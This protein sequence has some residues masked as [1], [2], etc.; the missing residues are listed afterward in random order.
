MPN[1]VLQEMPDYQKTIYQLSTDISKE[2]HYTT[3]DS[4]EQPTLEPQ[5][6][7][8]DGSSDDLLDTLTPRQDSV[9][10]PLVFMGVSILRFQDNLSKGIDSPDDISLT[11]LPKFFATIVIKFGIV[12]M[13]SIALIFLIILNLFRIFYLWF[14]IV[15]A[16][17]I[18]L[19]KVMKQVNMDF[20]V[21]GEI[22][23]QVGIDFNGLLRMVFAP[24]V[25]VAFLWLMLILI[26][27][28]YQ[29][30]I[31]TGNGTTDPCL[32]GSG[33][34]LN[35]TSSWSELQVNDYT[36]AIE[37]E[38]M[39]EKSGI[40][41]TLPY[42]IITLLVIGL[43]RVLVKM[44]S[45]MSS[46]GTAKWVVD[47]VSDTATKLAGSAQVI[48]LP[49]WWSIWLNALQW[50][51][52]GDKLRTAMANNLEKSWFD[53]GWARDDYQR[54]LDWF[55]WLGS[56]LTRRN[57]DRLSE[58]SSNKK[59]KPDEFF[60]Y[61]KWKDMDISLSLKDTPQRSGFL[62]N[63]VKTNSEYV[64]K[65]IKK[66]QGV[67]FDQTNEIDKKT[68]TLDSYY[69]KNPIK[70]RAVLQYLDKKLGW[71]GDIKTYKDFSVKKYNP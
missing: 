6:G 65:E 31:G 40:K 24:V 4:Q 36:I 1:A 3:S 43:M 23:K 8:R 2:Y 68:F 19:F 18:I 64:M 49:G 51:R 67:S 5:W 47:K 34:C 15:L 53:F 35:N 21:D 37:G 20:G 70:G 38:L 45:S 71:K 48:P 12:I 61:V 58:L 26:I 10:G 56:S 41:H 22:E 27:A 63:R 11:E 17:L 52:T 69:K 55:L 30:V 50:S 28:L 33:I 9:S 59:S 32:L 60:D 57:T 46:F 13:Y 7:T 39:S 42:L 14:F 66:D 29:W 62:T 44:A 16:P 25:Y 54:K